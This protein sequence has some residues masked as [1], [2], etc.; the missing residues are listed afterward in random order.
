MES[1]GMEANEYFYA[2]YGDFSPTSKVA[3]AALE[4]KGILE[5]EGVH[6]ILESDQ[7]S[8]DQMKAEFETI[9]SKYNMGAEYL[10]EKSNNP[11]SNTY[12][13][14]MRIARRIIFG[15]SVLAG[16]VLL[17]QMTLIYTTAYKRD[18]LIRKIFGMSDVQIFLPF[19]GRTAVLWGPDRGLQVGRCGGLLQHPAG[20]EPEVFKGCAG[21]FGHSDVPNPVRRTDLPDRQPFQGLRDL[22]DQWGG[23]LGYGL[24]PAF[25]EP[26]QDDH[27]ICADIDGRSDCSPCIVSRRRRDAC[28]H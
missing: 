24:G 14:E 4:E 27:S 25:S 11:E 18:L 6:I 10:T 22:A 23:F 26:D 17:W 13:S 5:N 7:V 16:V 3:I 19:M 28:L 21:H 12:G 15:V 20:P 8:E 2:L 9:L 1:Y